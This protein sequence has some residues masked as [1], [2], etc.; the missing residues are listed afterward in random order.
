[1]KKELDFWSLRKDMYDTDYKNRYIA[2]M[3]NGIVITGK[4]SKEIRKI[5]NT[6][7]FKIKLRVVDRCW[8]AKRFKYYPFDGSIEK[9]I[10]FK[11]ED[12]KTMAYNLIAEDL[13]NG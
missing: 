12:D 7:I 8:S 9:E 2:G 6:L 10:W 1:M 5:I 3:E 13:N 4:D 11:N